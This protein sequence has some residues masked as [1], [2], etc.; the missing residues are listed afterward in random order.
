MQ[1]VPVSVP[2]WLPLQQLFLVATV[3]ASLV[4]ARR[5]SGRDRRFGDVLRERFVLGVPW[6]TLLTM[7]GVLLVF[8]VVQGGWENPN[9]PVVIPFRSWSY[10]YPVG[11][12]FAGFAHNGVG[13]ITG[14][15]LGTVI[16]AP[17]VEYVIGHYPRE[18]G[19]QSFSSLR[20]NPFA[21]ILALPAGSVLVGLFTG[22]FSLG[23]VIGFSGVVFAYAGFAF[24]SRPL[25]AV[26]A[27]VSDR[28]VGLVYRGLRDPYIV[29]EPAS[30]F[31]SPWWADIAIQGH[32]IGILLG[33]VLGVA[34]LRRRGE[35]PDGFHLWFA[36]LIFGISESLWA[37]YTPLGA[38]RYALFRAVGVGL[39]FGF[40][41]LVASA[42]TAS[43]RSLT[44]RFD[45]PRRETA[46][47]V[48]FALLVALS[49]V[50]VPFG[51]TTV[52]GTVPDDAETID[53][54]DY[55]VTYVENVPNQ[56]VPS[57]NISVSL[58][59]QDYAFGADAATGIR[60]SGV[61]VYSEQR[62]AWIEAVSKGRLAF[63]GN[64]DVWVGGIGWRERVTANR[65]GWSLTGNGTA[66]KVYLSE[67]GGPRRLAYSTDPVT[68]SPVIAG[69][70]VSIRPTRQN[71]TVLVTRGNRTLG[72]V[73]MPPDSAEAQVGGLTLNR[74]GRDL[75]AIYNDTRVQVA[76]EAIPEARRN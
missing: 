62:R 36:A 30:A 40:A 70:N 38:N 19:S 21:R 67:A 27:L 8:W 18:R 46:A 74:T 12:I 66:Y 29:R 5:L 63:R 73:Q 20:T 43:D 39:M 75:Y 35:R 7:V 61:V 34:V 2:A 64:A 33:V 16:Y 17:L 1:Q 69:R 48:V 25:L 57:F 42:V 55:T 56:Y 65:Y 14:N 68:A 52:N 24:V 26:G 53:V 72:E 50:A 51:L 10:F 6:G 3:I 60:S 71:F 32:A 44:A 4:V 58:F 59:G 22:V 47:G 54:R 28:V 45:L 31:I 13:H 23:P 11:T 41:A 49:A 76:K 15:L 37:I 9:N